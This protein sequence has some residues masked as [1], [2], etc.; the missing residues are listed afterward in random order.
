MAKVG[1]LRNACFIFVICAATVITAPAQ[2]FTS[3]LSF[4]GT[5]GA[6]PNALIQAADG[7]FYGTTEK[8][9]TY[10]GGTVFKITPEGTLT[11]LHRFVYTDGAYPSGGLIQASDGN[12]YGTT[13]LGG[14]PPNFEGTVFK[15]TPDGTV[16]VLHIFGGADGR[17][18]QVLIQA[19]DGNYYG[20]TAGGGAYG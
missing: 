20:T 4:D 11:T 18:P 14:I 9:G 13:S 12:F 1:I 2:T 8:G 5:D 17:N 16:T 10:G 19:R 7:N 3:W 15:I 6:L